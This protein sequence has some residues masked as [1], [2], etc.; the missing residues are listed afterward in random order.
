MTL[1]KQGNIWEIQ[2]QAKQ[3]KLE[4]SQYKDFADYIIELSEHFQL[5][6]LRQF[7]QNAIAEK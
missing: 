6:K 7:I 3:L 2:Q 5:K 4:Q 1:I